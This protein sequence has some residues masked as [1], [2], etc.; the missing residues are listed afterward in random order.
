VKDPR[1]LPSIRRQLTLQILAG[2][3][4]ML[5]LAGLVF[6]AA[7]HRRIVGDFDRMLEAEADM[8]ARNTE[9][10]GHVFVWDV[11]ETYSEGSRETRDPAYCQLFLEDGTVVGLSQ[12]LGTDDL[13][14]MDGHQQLVWNAPLPNGRRGRL[15]QRTFLPTAD[16]TDPQTGPE[17]PREQTF[18][19][20][21]T[22]NPTNLHLV[23]VVARSREG[24]DRLLGSLGLAGGVLA[25]GLAGGLALL[26][27][28]AITRGLR[29]IDEM[30]AQI[31][32]I[33]PEALATRLQVARPPVEL[34]GIETAV[35]RL[36]DRVEKAFEKERRFSSDLA[37]ELRTPIA[38]LR[39]AC[40]I[41]GRWPD[42]VEQ[43]REFFQDT[44]MIAL[45]LE[46]IV[47]TMLTIS[48]CEDGT[49]PVQLRRICVQTLVRECWRHSATAAEAKE[50]RFDDRLAPSLIVECDEDKLGIIL[51]NLVEN[52]VAHSQPGTV[53]ECGG[54]ATPDGMELRL[55]NTAKD[56]ERADLEH[57]FDR[58]WRK[59][60]A[61]GDRDHIGL[62]LSI[63][64]G[65]C[66]LLGIRLSVDLHDLHESRLFEARLVFL[67]SSAPPPPKEFPVALSKS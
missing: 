33:A 42:D 66:E 53:V 47:A 15:L 19:I 31:A 32:A 41:G 9:R 37:H 27:R 21:A 23:L 56:L 59:D 44:G 65:L 25:L 64:R 50:L 20:P 61:R 48:R 24:L 67:A 39:T 17:D 7:I 22:V 2:A 62:G 51:R 54:G 26:V 11:P 8:L 4:G 30:N 36:L 46:K 12:T 28:S 45:Q 10:K 18:P 5:L 29:P 55:V 58:F 63:A 3:L 14:R 40:E 52:A 38:E 13:P 49:V 1:P 16:D 35:N 6:F 34:A 57:V 43:T 60:A